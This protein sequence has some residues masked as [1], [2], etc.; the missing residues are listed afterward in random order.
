MNNLRWMID[1]ENDYLQNH[2][3]NNTFYEYDELKFMSQF[4][5]KDDV[6]LDLGANV[7]NHSVFFSKFT[8]AKTIYAVEPIPRSYK[9]LL[10]N[11]KL[12]YCDNVNVDYI[13][14]AFGDR[15]CVG[16]PYMTCG[17]DSLGSVSIYPENLTSDIFDVNLKLDPVS[18]YPGDKFF[19]NVHLDFIKIDIDGMEIVALKGL[20]KTIENYRPKIFVE[21]VNGNKNDF[22]NWMK[23][24]NYSTHSEFFVGAYSNYMIIPQ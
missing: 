7:G 21:V 20:K 12:N 3:K 16:Y 4:I 17:K 11:L 8:E 5:K 1:N 6:I 18:V 23:E 19:E 24:N 13:G 14:I 9:M 2:L 10:C 22:V 15:E